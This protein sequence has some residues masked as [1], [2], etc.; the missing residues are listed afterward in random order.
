MKIKKSTAL[1][2]LSIV[3][4]LLHVLLSFFFSSDIQGAVRTVTLSLPLIVY[5]CYIDS[6]T[7]KI[8]AVI[9][10][11][12]VVIY[13]VFTMLEC[14]LS[15]SAPFSAALERG[16][17]L[18]FFL[19]PLT[20]VSFPESRKRTVVF[21]L[22]HV[23]LTLPALRESVRS[24]CYLY[25]ETVPRREYLTYMT[26]TGA[27]VMLTAVSEG[28]FNTKKNYL[29]D[30]LLFASICFSYPA[31]KAKGE[32]TTL[33]LIFVLTLLIYIGRSE[34]TVYNTE[35]RRI[36]LSS[37]KIQEIEHLRKKKKPRVYEIPPNV[38]VNDLEKDEE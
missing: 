16:V 35:R 14:L 8:K 26:L 23:L 28:I 2:S 13:V 34:K 17:A 25:K 27:T 6:N 37:L 3:F 32:N 10:S 11:S 31:E 7:V 22:L 38:P 29:S 5:L 33:W 21:I 4:V 24:Y 30:F 15:D 36:V 18:S 19:L 9:L 12:A 1:F 20:A